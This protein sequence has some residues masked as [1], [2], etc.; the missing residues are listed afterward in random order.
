[1]PRRRF[2]HTLI[3]A[4]AA[5]GTALAAMGGWRYA[6]A[7][8]PV[9]GPIVVISVDTLRAD[10]LSAYG[11]RKLG[12]PAIDRLAN[13]GIVFERAYSHAPLTLPAHVALLTGKLPFE[14][15]VRDDA[16]FVVKAGER[17]LPQMLRERGYATGAV[18]SSYL[19][20]RETGIAQ[21]FDFFDG[22]LPARAAGSAPWIRSAGTLVN[23]ARRD[24]ADSERIAE[25][26]LDSIGTSR[27]LLF[28]HLNDTHQPYARATAPANRDPYDAAVGYVDT[29]V[30]RLIAY[31]KSHQLYDRSTIVLLSDHGEGLGD[32]GDPE[33]GIFLYDEAIHIP[34]IVKQEGN[35][36]AGRRVGDAVQQIDLVPTILDL[37]KAPLPGSLRGQSLKPLLDG[38]ERLP[39]R[40]IYS[41]TLHGVFAF[42]WSGVT[43][44]TQGGYR[45]I[46]APDEELYDLDGD[47]HETESVVVV[48]PAVAKRLKDTLES[49]AGPPPRGASLVDGKD[50]RP[51]LNSYRHAIALAREHRWAQAVTALQGILR[52]NPTVPSVWNDLAACAT[53]IDRLDLVAAA[54]QQLAALKPSDPEPRLALADTLLRAKKLDEARVQARLASETALEDDA[55][56][57]RE[58]HEL[59]VRIAL[60]RHDYEEARLAA[61]SV[62]QIDHG[63]SAAAY[64]EARA[65]YDAGRYG[66]AWPVFEQA[67]AATK[68][69]GASQIQDLHFYAG[70]TLLRLGRPEGELELVEELR[71]FPS[72][73]RARTALATLYHTTGRP[74]EAAQ[75]VAEM[76]RLAPTAESYATA[77]RLW[78]AF[79][80]TGHAEAARREGRRFAAEA[81]SVK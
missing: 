80:E 68:N 38:S 44:V 55:G 74:E 14:T 75:V 35:L 57:R 58:A 18:V 17:L 66:D 4:G 15:G 51:F 71:R 41:E 22:D 73:A 13:D 8:A 49:L 10:H 25:R 39:D 77:A 76:T 23:D 40:P 21:G 70:D 33:H 45:Y 37:V 60:A 28:L 3:L 72:N 67:L 48:S 34:L 46:K 32:H 36:G 16:G 64:V 2:R 52:S 1:M 27:A 65:L 19:L 42:G 9:N 7:S 62:Q 12:T 69:P 47:P 56:A 59:E 6:R 61:D 26:W 5:V 63:S 24:G 79:G 81:A 53:A 50:E 78:R 43:A 54:Y 11:Y 20:R 29:I 31:L 30:A